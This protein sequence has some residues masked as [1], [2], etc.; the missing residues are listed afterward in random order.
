MKLAVIAPETCTAS[1]NRGGGGDAKGG[2]NLN[3]VVVAATA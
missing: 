3:G 2:T 1:K